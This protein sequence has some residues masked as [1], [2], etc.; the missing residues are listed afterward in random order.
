M[1]ADERC[2]GMPLDDPVSL[3]Q[4]LFARGILVAEEYPVWMCVELVPAFVE[5]IQ[6]SK[7]GGG[8]GRVDHHGAL[9]LGT[10][11]PN[12]IQ[13]GIVDAQQLARGETIT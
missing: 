7:E 8:I 11:L 1:R 4:Q 13:L 9:V 3:C 2:A 6:R 10:Q 5:T 12:R